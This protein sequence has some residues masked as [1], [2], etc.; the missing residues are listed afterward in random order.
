MCFLYLWSELNS[1]SFH[2][3]CFQWTLFAQTVAWH[4]YMSGTGSG[5]NGFRLIR[6]ISSCLSA[7]STDDRAGWGQNQSQQTYGPSPSFS[8]PHLLHY[9]Y[10]DA[11]NELIRVRLQ[12]ETET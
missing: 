5:R 3:V 8:P 11:L 10:N 12:G 1:V 4:P 7:G 9:S 2:L 6:P